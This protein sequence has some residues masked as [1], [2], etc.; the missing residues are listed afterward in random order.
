MGEFVFVSEV[1]EA[2]GDL[3]LAFIRLSF[4]AHFDL[5]RPILGG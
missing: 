4:L 5:E 1:R 3:K 2:F